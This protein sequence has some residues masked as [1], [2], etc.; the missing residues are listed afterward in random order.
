M[1]I[2]VEDTLIS[3][4]SVTLIDTDQIIT[5]GHCHTPAQALSSSVTFDYQTDCDGNRLPGYNPRFFKVKKVLDHHYEP[6]TFGDFSHLKLATAPPGIPFI[7]MRPDLPIIGEQI[8]GI[9]HPNGAIK[10]LSIPHSGGFDT[11][12]G[13]TISGVQVPKNFHVSGGSS[14]S[15]L[16]DT[17][18]RILGVLS[19]G[20]P[21]HTSTSFLSYFPISSILSII[22]PLPPTP[23]TRDVMVVFDHS[24]S[25][26]QLDTTGRTKIE[27][28][29]DAVSLFVQLVRSGVGNRVGLVS[30]S[31]TATSP[32]DVPIANF[33]DQTKLRLIGNPPFAGGKVGD[34]VPTGAT[35][36]GEGLDAARQQFPV[37]GVNPR[38]ILL[39][40]DGLQN[41]PRFISDVEGMLG[42]IDIHAVGLGTDANLNGAL[43]SKLATD[44]NGAYSRAGSG[45]A[46]QKFFSHAFGN[47]FETGLITDPEFDLPAH[48]NASQPMSFQ[49]CGEEAV[50]VAVGWDK[51]AGTILVNLTTPSGV[52][53]TGRSPE[54]EESLGRTWT[55]LRVPLPHSGERDGTWNATVFRPSNSS[56][57][58]LHYFI[59]VIPTGGPRLLRVPDPRIYYTGDSINPLV[60]LRY[61][62]GSWPTD[63]K[64]QLTLSRPNASIG[65]ILSQGK[66]HAPVTIAGDTVPP[67][68]ATLAAIEQEFGLVTT[69]VDETFDLS[70]DSSS[71]GGTFEPAALFGNPL[72]NK[73]VTEGDYIFH[74]RATYG[75]GSCA[76]TRELLWSLHV[77]VGI[78]PSHTNVTIIL[79]GDGPNGQR[80]GNVTV[81][82]GDQYGNKLGPGKSDAA[83]ITGGAGTT[84]TG[85][86]L[87]N[88]DGSYTAPIVW[89][90]VSR[91]PPGVVIGQPG[92][93]PV[94]VQQPSN[95]TGDCMMGP[96]HGWSD[97]DEPHH[98]WPD[99]GE[100]H[101]HDDWSDKN[102]NGRPKQHEKEQ[103]LN[104]NFGSSAVRKR[105]VVI[106]KYY[107]GCY[108]TIA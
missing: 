45:V 95:M 10:K 47:I 55:F 42:G 101:H 17:A 89:D 2:S 8:F 61:L 84:I 56:F 69:L 35:S 71:T 72:S 27:V 5:A 6:G 18:G 1:I 94:V 74:A 107:N 48:Q 70:N 99:K 28:A 85:G 41:T 4:C 65:S 82:P 50:T 51:V 23:I 40:T 49:V 93:S 59:N 79:I 39:M 13:S 37:P 103:N 75:Q 77:D 19:G 68:Q 106:E 22:A 86:V 52:T 80:T 29:R 60:L 88:G 78:D 62:D 63:A 66:L 90:P 67:I 57:Q 31:T 26:S 20:D 87:D 96:H 14:G 32:V 91:N 36:I 15:G 83:S 92:R 108:S 98:D 16:F 73:L 24:G 3:T 76:S 44:H 21:C 9:H 100:P 46:L 54:V 7:Q 105:F 11:V 64:A 97:K 38:A 25:M 102:K 53:I 34:L 12:I 81:V 43:L 33:D 104:V 30:F 58:P